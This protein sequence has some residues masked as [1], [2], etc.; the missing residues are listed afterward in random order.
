MELLRRETRYRN[1]VRDAELRLRALWDEADSKVREE[2]QR[3]SE[4]H[5]ADIV[6]TFRVRML[7]FN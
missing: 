6:D 7:C 5:I 1:E 3:R 2:E 4:T